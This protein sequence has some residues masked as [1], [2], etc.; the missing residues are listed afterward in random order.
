MSNDVQQHTDSLLSKRELLLDI[1]CETGI[2][3][4]NVM[5]TAAILSCAE[6]S[7]TIHNTELHL[8]AARKSAESILAAIDTQIARITDRK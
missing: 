6:S 1:Q 4:G 7:I 5:E 3:V 2:I 8:N